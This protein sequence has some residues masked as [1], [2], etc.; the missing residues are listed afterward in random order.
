MLYYNVNDSLV[1]TSNDS[2][3]FIDFRTKNIRKYLNESIAAY[4]NSIDDY[5]DF[6]SCP[7][8]TGYYKNKDCLPNGFPDVKYDFIYKLFKDTEYIYSA[9]D[10][11]IYR[12]PYKEDFIYELLPTERALSGDVKLLSNFDIYH[13]RIIYVSKK[14]D[15]IFYE[16]MAQLCFENLNSH[17]IRKLYNSTS[18][19]I[20][21][22]KVRNKNKIWIFNYKSTNPGASFFILNW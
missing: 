1:C 21:F 4:F 19:N 7:G 13:S 8:R 6:F 2:I 22:K 15:F 12:Y 18:Y 11:V 17:E 20:S 16:T 14:F 5:S 10:N 9:T 3:C